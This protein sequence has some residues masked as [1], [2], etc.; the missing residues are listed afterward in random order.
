MYFGLH[1]MVAINAP[2]LSIYFSHEPQWY[3]TKILE[4]WLE[5]MDKNTSLKSSTGMDRVNLTCIKGNWYQL[6]QHH[7]RH[8]SLVIYIQCWRIGLILAATKQL[9]EWFSPSVCLSVCPSV[10]PSVCHTFLTMFPSS[11]HHGICRSYYQ[12]QKWHQC[13]RSRSEVKG[14]GHRGQHLT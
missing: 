7:R 8:I 13:K 5:I 11:Y 3:G 4:I 1:I 6:K 12:W 14:Q 9:Y 10:C 2:F